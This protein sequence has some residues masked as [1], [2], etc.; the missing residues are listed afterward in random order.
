MWAPS[1]EVTVERNPYQYVPSPKETVFWFPI[2][3]ALLDISEQLAEFSELDT[4]IIDETREYY[5]EIEKLRPERK[6]DIEKGR[7]LREQFVSEHK[8]SSIL[9]D[10]ISEG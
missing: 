8:F 6:E 9:G 2:Y 7:K 3:S 10:D 4:S 1:Q 5:S